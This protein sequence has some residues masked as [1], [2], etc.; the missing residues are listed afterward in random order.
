[1]SIMIY[2]FIS[3]DTLGSF[4]L[5]EIV[6]FQQIAGSLCKVCRFMKLVISSKGP[7]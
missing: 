4:T 3:S 1:M 6:V 2:P 7:M 5:R